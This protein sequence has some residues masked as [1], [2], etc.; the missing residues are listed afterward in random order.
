MTQASDGYPTGCGRRE[1]FRENEVSGARG[2][3]IRQE[4]SGEGNHVIVR[5]A[6]QYLLAERVEGIYIWD[7]DGERDIDGSGRPWA[8]R[9]ATL[10]LLAFRRSIKNG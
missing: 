8:G 1:G 5:V 7:E 9:Q 3:L 4:R 10:A 6:R 2:G